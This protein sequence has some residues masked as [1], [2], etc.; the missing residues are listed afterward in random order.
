MCP[1]FLS[2]SSYSNLVLLNISALKE[3]RDSLSLIIFVSCFLI[4]DG[5]F[6]DTSMYINLSIS[7]LYGM[8]VLF[9]KLNLIPKKSAS[10]RM[11]TISILKSIYLKMLITFFCTVSVCYLFILRRINNPSSFYTPILYF[12]RI[13]CRRG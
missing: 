12:E 9:S 7:F 3:F 1:N 6:D 13:F 8:Y 4:C 11:V 10:V 2:A 5:W